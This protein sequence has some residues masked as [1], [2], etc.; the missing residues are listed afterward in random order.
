MSGND[1]LLHRITARPEVVGGRPI[2][3]DGRASVE[4]V[5]SLIAQETPVAR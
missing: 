1:E 5:L 4:L 2:V 3:S